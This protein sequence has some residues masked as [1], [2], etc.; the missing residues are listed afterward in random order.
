MPAL[1]ADIDT[2]DGRHA[3]AGSENNP[4][5]EQARE[6]IAML[7][8]EPTVLIDT[9]GGYHVWYALETPL[10]HWTP[11]GQAT[12]ARWAQLWE[13]NGAKL[14]VHVDGKPSRDIQAA[15]RPAGSLNWKKAEPDWKPATNTTEE[16]A[17]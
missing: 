2:I 15:P 7:P 14:G 6:L 8:F 12:L 4:T 17:A 16:K 1:Y 9:S 3:D 11:E 5:R 13:D 10:K